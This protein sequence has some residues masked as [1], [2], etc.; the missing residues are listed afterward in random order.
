MI[1][2]PLPRREQDCG[3]YGS[4]AFSEIIIRIRKLDEVRSSAAVIERIIKAT[5]HQARDYSLVLPLQLLDRAKEAQRTFNIV[6]GVIA[7]ISLLVGGIGIMNVMLASVSERQRE[8]GIRRAIGANRRQILIRFLA[9]ALMLTLVGGLLGLVIGVVIVI[10]IGVYSGLDIAIV[11]WS[12][13]L[14]LFMASLVCILSGSYPAMTASRLN[15][16]EA[17]RGN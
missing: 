14:S 7:S 16:I 15:P 6:L 13:L 5:H 12:L 1:L 4:D 10:V 17:L 8:I 11:P 9:E 2:I 3:V